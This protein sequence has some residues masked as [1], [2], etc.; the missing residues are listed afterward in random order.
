VALSA[1]GK[2]V[3][4]G[5]GDGTVRLWETRTGVP[6]AVLEGHTGGVWGVALSADGRLAASGGYDGTVRLWEA[7]TGMF[8]RLLRPERRYE[9]L[10]FTGLTGIT[11]AQRAA[12]LA[13]GAV[14]HSG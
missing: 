1:D 13:L 14:E 10:D 5:G 7:S 4:S 8:L 12:L 9:R 3:A 6:V 2:L 11:A